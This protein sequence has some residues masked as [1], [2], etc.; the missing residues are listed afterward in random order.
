VARR[1]KHRRDQSSASFRGTAEGREPGIQNETRSVHLDSGS[2]ADA[3]SRNDSKVLV[4]RF[5]AAH[6][7]RGDV[8]LWSFTQDPLAVADYG[9]LENADG[10]R[11]FEIEHLRPA[12]DFLVARVAGVSDRTAAEALRNLELYVP[13]DRLPPIEEEA[14]WYISD[15]IGVDAHTPDGAPAGKVTAVHNFGAGDVLELTGE[16]GQ[17]VMLPFTAETVPEVDVAAGRIVVVLPREA[18]DVAVDGPHDLP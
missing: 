1:E 15:L 13:R 2:G 3:P 12:K 9:P 4:A 7:V 10:R 5:G 17:S 8:K 16:R 11:T 18:D 14:T 6:G